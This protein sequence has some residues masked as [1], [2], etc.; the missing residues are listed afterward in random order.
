MG[1]KAKVTNSKG[2]GLVLGLILIVVGVILLW[3][4]EGRTV[5]T[6]SAINEAQK[7]YVDVTSEKIDSKNEGKL[8]ATT[9]K[10]DITNSGDLKDGKFNI[11]IKAAKLE[12]KVE[13]F[14]WDESCT[15]DEDDHKDCKY[16]KKWSDVLIDSTNFEKSGYTN[17]TSFK[18]ESEEYKAENIKVGEYALPERLLERLSYNENL[19]NEKLTEMYKTPV[20]NFKLEGNYLINSANASDPQVGDLRISYSYASDGEVSMLGVQKDNTLTAFTGKKGKSIFEIRRGKQTGKE[21]L[22]NLT[23]SNQRTKWFLRV[24]GTIA[25]MLGF[26]SLFSPL[27]YFTDKIPVVRTIVN[28]GTGIVATILGLGTSLIVIAVAWFRYRP[29][30]SIVL[31]AIVVG[32]LLFLKF[33]K[34]PTQRKEK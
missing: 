34:K 5:K 12:R 23:K 28:T 22:N 10:L 11:T 2:G 17:P 16:E 32:L 21:I 15:T 20:D 24:V 29:V 33:G 4:N 26:S 19:N 6:Q 14:Q 18:Y 27:Q 25:V 30:L 3:S 1:K 13:M 8:I 31:I 7:E 9:G